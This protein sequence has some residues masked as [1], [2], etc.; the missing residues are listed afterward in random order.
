MWEGTQEEVG[1]KRH[2][3]GDGPHS[4]AFYW[5][6]KKKKK[7]VNHSMT[8]MNYEIGKAINKWRMRW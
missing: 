3:Q 4:A 6:H 7:I 8:I 5:A 1:Y 2:G